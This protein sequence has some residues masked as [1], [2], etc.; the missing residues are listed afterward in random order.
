MPRRPQN[1][2]EAMKSRPFRATDRQWQDLKLVT[3]AAVRAWVTK[4]A[5]R[6]RRMKPNAELSGPRPLA[7][8]GSRSNDGLERCQQKETK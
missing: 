8:E 2:G 7:A 1:E 4:K 3:P 6:L 5:A